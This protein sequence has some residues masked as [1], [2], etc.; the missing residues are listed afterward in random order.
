MQTKTRT[1][2]SQFLAGASYE[3]VCRIEK[4]L[5]SGTGTHLWDGLTQFNQNLFELM[6]DVKIINIS[7]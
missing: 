6:F 4:G 5:D 1:A 2:P 3:L 7:Y